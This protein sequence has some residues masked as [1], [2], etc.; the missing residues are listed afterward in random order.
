MTRKNKLIL[1][2]GLII[3]AVCLSIGI[4]KIKDS[5]TSEDS[6]VEPDTKVELTST[7]DIK[8]NEVT[9]DDTGNETVVASIDSK[10]FKYDPFSEDAGW[11]NESIF[12]SRIIVQ[13]TG[14]KEDNK[15][16]IQ[17]EGSDST[18]T[19]N[20]NIRTLSAAESQAAIME[21]VKSVDY[22]YRINVN[23]FSDGFGVYMN[24]KYELVVGRIMGDT[25]YISGP[26][27][28]EVGITELDRSVSIDKHREKLLIDSGYRAV[29]DRS[30]EPMLEYGTPITLGSGIDNFESTPMYNAWDKQDFSMNDYGGQLFCDSRAESKFGKGYYIE[31]YNASSQLYYGYYLVEHNGRIFKATGMSTYQDTLKDITMATVDTCVYPY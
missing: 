6:T 15:Q 10:D 9:E 3:L 18:N 27:G 31:L 16:G 4:Y 22:A 28:T 12:G 5:K 8:N 26:N 14:K 7:D 13:G 21:E 11:G 30:K 2:A 23:D 1:A 19:A 29:Y 20:K 17:I 25:G 24:P